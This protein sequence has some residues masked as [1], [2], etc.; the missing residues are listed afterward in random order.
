MDRVVWKLGIFELV[1]TDYFTLIFKLPQKSATQIKITKWNLQKENGW[2]KY[3]ELTSNNFNKTIEEIE[4]NENNV[5]TIVKK[6]TDLHTKLC[7]GNLVKSPINS[8]SNSPKARPRKRIKS[9]V[10]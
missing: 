2:T 4:K 10:S 3:S 6:F 7:L 8:T 9:K 5:E 1:H